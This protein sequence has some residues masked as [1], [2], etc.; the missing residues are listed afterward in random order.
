MG[1]EKRRCPYC[2][3][4]VTCDEWMFCPGECVDAY[5]REVS[6]GWKD[7]GEVV[8]VPLDPPVVSSDP[9][10]QPAHYTAIPGVE[11]I[12]LAEHLMFNRG[13]VVKYVTRAGKKDPE[14]ELEDL[15]KA[16]WYLNR[17]IDRI[18]NQ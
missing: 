2:V 17:E 6:N 3:K 9:I 13:N 1:A 8:T 14:K 18:E 11:P 16:Q 10:N 15:K 7:W 12:D 5:Y 4:D